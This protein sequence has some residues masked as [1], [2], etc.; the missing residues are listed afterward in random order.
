MYDY[1]FFG[2]QNVVAEPQDPKWPYTV[3]RLKEIFGVR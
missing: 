1:S 2:N 3:D